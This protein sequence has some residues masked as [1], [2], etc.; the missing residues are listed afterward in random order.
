MFQ[1]LFMTLYNHYE[2]P[3][4]TNKNWRE[5][6]RMIYLIWIVKNIHTGR[7]F[8][9]YLKLLTGILSMKNALCYKAFSLQKMY[10]FSCC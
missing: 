7:N 8:A 5:N 9:V 3:Q 4:D 1:R 6:N 10:V 2:T